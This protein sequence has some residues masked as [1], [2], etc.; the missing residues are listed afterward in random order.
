MNKSGLLRRNFSTETSESVNNIY[1]LICEQYGLSY[2]LGSP[3]GFEA[4]KG[5]RKNFGLGRLGQK[6][7]SICTFVDFEIDLTDT[8]SIRQCA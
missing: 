5:R 3:A 4:S 7:G 8:R 2:T 6:V 1:G